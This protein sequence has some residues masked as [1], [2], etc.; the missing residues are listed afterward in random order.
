MKDKEVSPRTPLLVA[1]TAKNEDGSY[2]LR[3]ST[4]NYIIVYQGD[5]EASLRRLTKPVKFSYDQAKSLPSTT[6]KN[7]TA[8]GLFF[9]EAEAI[10]C[11]L[12]IYN[13]LSC[14]SH[15]KTVRVNRKFLISVF[16]LS[17]AII[18]C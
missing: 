16:A 5:T 7:D 1:T 6:A 13:E 11:L 3:V 12:V 15:Q 2:R 14:N 17:K 18:Q 8:K 9:L 10:S 4:T